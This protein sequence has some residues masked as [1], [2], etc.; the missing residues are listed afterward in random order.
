LSGRREGAFGTLA[1]GT[2][3]TNGTRVAGQIYRVNKSVSTEIQ[4]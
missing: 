4:K 2:E 1:G 3:T